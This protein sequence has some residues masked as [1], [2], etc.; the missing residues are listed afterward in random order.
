[1]T[2]NELLEKFFQPAR[3]MD[4][5]DNGFTE[6][7][8]QQIAIHDVRQ[9]AFDASRLSRLWT[10]FCVIVAVTLFVLMRG[11]EPISYGL[12]ML[13]NTPPTQQQ[14]LTLFVSVVVVGLLVIGDIIGRERY[15]VL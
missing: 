1:M 14:M 15:S 13:I 6:R 8:M 10:A 5:A 9:K 2:D 12:M 3:Q 4:I 11:W 7:V